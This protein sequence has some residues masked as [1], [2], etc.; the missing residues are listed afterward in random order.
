MAR[1]TTAV[2]AAPAVL[3]ARA[4]LLTLCFLLG[5]GAAVPSALAKDDEPRR[6]TVSGR[7]EAEAVPDIA[8]LSIGVETEARTPGEAL[9]EN[10][11]RMTAVMKRLK[12]AG[13]DDRDLRT[14]QLGI[15]P[16]FAERRQP[17]ETVGYRASNQLTVTIR[18]IDRLG[19]LLDQAVAD[20]ANSVSGPTFSIADPEPLL[21]AARD[22]AVKDAIAKAERMAAAA[23]V[24]LGEVISI[25]EAN[26][27]MP[28][29]PRQ[30][31]AEAMAAAT[32]IAPGETTIAAGVTMTFELR[33]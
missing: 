33:H 18:D 29:L 11:E 17:R 2:L 32:P 31:R 1:M 20:G 30:M 12:D 4:V 6:I 10:A 25:S 9:L 14:S 3:A 13:I 22:A 8:T 5:V 23:G 27:G 7:A 21:A 26:G 15:W 24:E 19:T 16:I 28:I